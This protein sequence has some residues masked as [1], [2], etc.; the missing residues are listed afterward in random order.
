M[1]INEYDILIDNILDNLFDSLDISKIDSKYLE[2][3][4]SD[5]FKYI[6]NLEKLTSN[7]DDVKS[8]ENITKLIIISYI[9][10]NSFLNDNINNI[11]TILI[12]NKVLKS[13]ELGTIMSLFDYLITLMEVLNEDNNE[14]LLD[15]YK[16]NIKYKNAIDLL[17]G[18]G[19]ENT[20]NLKGKTKKH[21]HNLIKVIVIDR[22][23]RKKFRKII[24]NLIYQNTES[25]KIIE[26][27]LPKLKLLDFSNVENILNTN[28]IKQGLTKEILN[29]YESYENEL[30]YSENMIDKISKLF[31][32]KL[33]I[34]ITD[35]FLRYHKITEKYEKSSNQIK[36]SDRENLKDQTKIRYIITKI[37]KLKDY[38]SKKTIN[39]KEILKDIEKMF[40]KSLVHRKAIVYNEIEELSIINKLVQQGKSAI[41][42]NEFYHD[43][44]NL[45]KSSYINFK[46][47]KNNGFSYDTRKTS[48]KTLTV[49]RY[50][51]IESLED[52]TLPNKN[53]KVET[54]TISKNNYAQIVGVLILDKKSNINKLKLKDLINIRKINENGF[55]S[56]LKVLGN[57]INNSNN[58]NYYWV[59][60]L[61]KDKFTQDTYEY[62]EINSDL[63]NILISKLYD[64]ALEEIYNK[65]ITKLNS[66]KTLDLYY[67]NYINNYY[68]YNYIQF[69][70]YSQY[71]IN[72]NKKIISLIPTLTSKD[73]EYENKIF[74]IL[75]K[76]HKLPEIKDVN[77]VIPTFIIPYENEE[78]FIDLS[79]ENVYCQ[80]IIDW[81]YLSK[82]RSKNP[83]KHSEHLYEFIKKYVMTNDDNEY[84]C[85]SCK[86]YIDIQHYL[87]TPYDGGTTGIDIIV[88]STQNL[89]EIKE[90][91]KF[92]SLIKQM[93][94]AVEKVAQ[95][96]NFSYYLGN[97]KIYKLRRQEI[98]KQVIDIINLHDKTL[99]VKNMSRRERE[100]K[101]SQNY[102]V[103][104]DFTFF[105]IFPLSNDIFI[106]TSA[107]TDKF[108]K[109]KR[110]NIITYILFFMILDLND[111]QVNMFEFNK[112]CNFLLFR[113]FK[114]VIFKNLKLRINDSND[115]IEITK[116]ETLCY[117]IYYTSCMISKYKLW[118]TSDT[119]EKNISIIQRQVIHTI[120]DL[121]NSLMEVNSNDSKNYLY[122]MI[123]SK[124]INKI[125]T[126]FKNDDVLK[127]IEERE[128]KKIIVNSSTNKIQILKSSIKSI[129]LP[130]KFTIFI[131]ELRKYNFDNRLFE[132]SKKMN[133]RDSELILKNEIEK[134]NKK[135]EKDNLIQLARIYDSK[136]LIRR[137]K[138]SYEEAIKFDNKYFIEMLKNIQ[139]QKDKK[140]R[141]II[142]DNTFDNLKKEYNN[143]NINRN[144]ID[145]LI[146]EIKEVTGTS[147]K[148]NNSIFHISI[149]KFEVNYDYL[150][151]RLQN[152]FYL[153]INDNKVS[154]KTDNND[155]VYE[156]YDASNDVKLIFKF[157]TLHYLGYKQA[158]KK[159]TDMTNLNI[160][161]NYIPSI[162]EMFETLGLKRNNFNFESKKDAINELR[163]SLNN[164]KDYIRQYKVFSSQIKYKYNNITNPILKYYMNKIDSLILRKN[165]KVIFDNIDIILKFEKV[166]INEI[167]KFDNL[168]KLDMVNLSESYNKLLD[169]LYSQL[170]LLIEFNPNKYIKLHLIYF[171]LSLLNYFY[172]MNFNQYTSFDLLRYNYI[173][174]ADLLQEVRDNAV[175]VFDDT[176][177]ENES[178]LLTE[179]EQTNLKN[180]IN[181]DDEMLDA[182]DAE[183]EDYDDEEGGEQILFSD[184]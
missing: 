80:H 82:L 170:L 184:D 44:L 178:N 66:Y 27:V 134:I 162:R 139:I 182:L 127:N 9:V 25:T 34:P 20:M 146:S 48:A 69:F 163:N 1:F 39:N 46:D 171:I 126:L 157:N 56:A 87:S 22:Y 45:R 77:K 24:F 164:L 40:Y 143:Y 175:E 17:N 120:I 12:K 133:E 148:L 119:T 183:Q 98:I 92:S 104:S 50:A 140:V 10:C 11:K 137:F 174:S 123:S 141:D 37:E 156:I 58:E 14:K 53:I 85:K 93:D 71:N 54:R 60:D 180:Q 30:N 138:I 91:T 19:Y 142:K 75:G 101:A 159:F 47:F 109:M 103:S 169:Y 122:E 81:T 67:S 129:L 136:G 147:I 15:L 128:K 99:R 51:G 4:L 26:V 33:V 95:I 100:I 132:I 154:I 72:I 153:L 161:I 36:R 41:D 179:D 23:Y 117:I 42:S 6:K 79:E 31:S 167:F 110:N 151:N 32:S 64:F 166:K 62:G 89:N 70:K 165:K 105:F 2:N 172:N 121:I 7:K 144:N 97:D 61:E 131:D 96:N 5:N 68:Q 52:K 112:T 18:L 155:K 3:K 115:V 111:S 102:G 176:I 55:E 113:K 28:E 173:L 149:S 16:E 65:I 125:N 108:K 84:I 29:L 118:Y 78:K 21:K 63:S 8:I 59:F 74:G 88:D 150:G 177:I 160:Y 130:D 168:N 83:N 124:I 106:S 90:Y 35:E 152:S 158:S 86:Q 57:R 13:E 135:Y 181:D 73:D 114:D 43:L 94:K 116:L 38:Y 49:I 76:V 145:K 107:E